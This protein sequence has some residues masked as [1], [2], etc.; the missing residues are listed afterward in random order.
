MSHPSLEPDPHPGP[1]RVER[2]EMGM[3]RS[4]HHCGPWGLVEGPGMCK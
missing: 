3:R 4:E 1:L 2:G